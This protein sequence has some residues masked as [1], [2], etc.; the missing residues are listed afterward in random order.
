[1]YT[2]AM[3]IHL[4]VVGG[5]AGDMFLA[6]LLDT[7]PEYNKD[8]PSVLAAAGFSD[9]VHVEVM[10]A[11]DGVI[12]GT[13][14]QVRP[15]G[16][17]QGHHHRHF[18]EIRD[19]IQASRLDASTKAA[20]IGI[21][22]RLAEAE[23]KVHGV[24]PERVAFHE[25]GAWDSIADIVCAAWLITQ[26]NAKSWSLSRL[27]LGSGRVKTIHGLL[28]VP[29]P[30]TSLLLAGFDCFD[31]G[32]EGER[33]TPTGAALLCYL[34]PSQTGA[35]RQGKLARSGYGLGTKT[36]PGISNMLRCL[37]LTATE[38]DTE[39]SWALDEVLQL[40][41]EVDDQTPEDLG[42]ALDHIRATPGVLDVTQ[43]VAYGKKGRLTIAIRVLAEPEAE[44]GVTESCFAQ[45]TTLGIRSQ[46]IKRHILY[47]ASQTIHHDGRDYAVKVAERASQ[48]SAKVE[49]DHLQTEAG[50]HSERQALRRKLETEAVLDT[51]QHKQSDTP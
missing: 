11:D 3:H 37:V 20:A 23:G 7:F 15:A 13:R 38:K 49:M 18:S 16:D 22:Q 39:K 4:D 33:I 10:A 44:A 40:A 6:A 17:A 31:D 42:V 48:T 26:I 46:R 5:V 14:V 25:V 29:A 12:T 36:F 30:A 2:A 35:A 8:L 51:I 41:F 24:A 27:P 28:P 50:N 45:T 32:I 34:A 43:S 19:L 47:R 21:F 9:L 1:M